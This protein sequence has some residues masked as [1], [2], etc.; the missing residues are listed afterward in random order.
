M[1]SYNSLITILT[2]FL[3]NEGAEIHLPAKR[4]L[5]IIQMDPIHF[6]QMLFQSHPF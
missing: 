1:F 4:P 6:S 5:F 2:I 3:A